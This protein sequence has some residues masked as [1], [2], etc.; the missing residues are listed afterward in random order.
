MADKALLVLE[1]GTVFAG[2]PFGAPVRSHGEVVFATAMTGYQEMLTDPSFEGSDGRGI[3]S[4]LKTCV[5]KGHYDL[6]LTGVQAED[7][8]AQV[9]GMLAAM[10]DYPLASLVTAIEIVSG[11]GVRTQSPPSSGQE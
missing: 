8:A 1:D 3:A 6:I 4:I 9:G 10:L 5:L 2:R 11:P 7:G